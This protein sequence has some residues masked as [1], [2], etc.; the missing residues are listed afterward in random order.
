MGNKTKARKG[1][2]RLQR[3]AQSMREFAKVYNNHKICPLMHDLLRVLYPGSVIKDKPRALKRQIATYAI[4]RKTHPEFNLPEL[5]LRKGKDGS[6]IAVPEGVLEQLAEF[7]IDA[8]KLQKAKGV[9][10]TSAQFGATLNTEVFASLKRYA[11]YLG[12]ALV[13]LPIKYGQI[14]TV[15]Q[16]AIDKR[17]LTSTF[18]ENLKGYMLFEDFSF[19]E[20]MLTLNVMRLRPTLTR[21]LT[22]AICERGGMAS[23][24]FAAPKLELEFRPRLRHDYP[25]AIMTTGAVTHP[26]YHVDNLGQQDRT[27]EIARAEHTYS[28][29]IVEFSSRKTF[30]FRQLL[31][32]TT[33][34][35]YDI[36]PVHG[37]AVYVTPKAVELRPDDVVAAVLGDWHTTKTHP[38]VRTITF[39]DMLPT[40]K[41]KHVVL[42]DLFDGDSINHWEERQASRRA[43]K[44]PMQADSL[45]VELNALITELNWMGSC[46][47]GATLHIVASNHNEFLRRYIEDLRWVSDNTNLA[48]GAK[49][50]SALQE[51]L[52]Q[53]SPE[54]HELSPMDPVNWWVNQHAPS[55]RT[56]GRRGKLILP[57]TPDSK[58]I[59]LSLH[60]DIGPRG[61]KAGSLVAF[62]KW[63]QWIII[64]HDHSAAILGP[65]WRVGTST[66]L[67]E[68]YVS[69][70][71]T[72]WTH[73]HALVYAN[74]Q[75]QL[76]N[77]MNGTYHGQRK[78]R[79]K[80][81]GL[82]TG[83]TRKKASSKR[84]KR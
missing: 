21:F 65:I 28:A 73:T 15:H 33:G 51:D 75:R 29:I 58:K 13:V 37:G 20:G 5:I 36:D 8:K 77:I 46:M 70:P 52:K 42:H 10:V 23:Q 34:E 12:Y 53:R 84:K 22:D 63:N 61:Q 55:V 68:H 74:G 49:L 44:G 79:P 3:V 47:P 83:A 71:A 30:H 64:G 54:K 45:E 18:D 14:K 56:H 78:Q 7:R 17:V 2:G 19:A 76:I 4:F 39:Q 67:V 16:K 35:F 82:G 62:R 24:I 43:Y 27:G 57:D 60:G 69:G 81:A 66:H 40:L 26:D 72:N 32:T 48:I 25:K 38:D 9:I 11:E 31:S 59:L 80:S 1:S 50:F 6:M 41:P